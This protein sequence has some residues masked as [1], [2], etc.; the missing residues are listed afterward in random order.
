MLKN[1]V[2]AISTLVFVASASMAYAGDLK[3][4]VPPVHKNHVC[5][6][7]DKTK[8]KTTKKSN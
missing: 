8:C 3:A 6:D 1:T 4:P 5:K 2:L 7:T